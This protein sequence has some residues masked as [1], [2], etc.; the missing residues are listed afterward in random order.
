MKI[1]AQHD[2]ADDGDDG[3]QGKFILSASRRSMI[4]ASV[5]VVMQFLPVL[6]SSGAGTTTIRSDV[7]DEFSVM[8]AIFRVMGNIGFFIA[9]LLV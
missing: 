3:N 8:T 6:Y 1:V 4:C 5:S 9:R 7:F 2:K